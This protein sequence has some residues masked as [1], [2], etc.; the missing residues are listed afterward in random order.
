LGKDNRR[1]RFLKMMKK[2]IESLSLLL[3]FCLSGFMVGALTGIVDAW[4]AHRLFH[5]AISFT[6]ISTA[7]MTYSCLWT[8]IGLFVSAGFGLWGVLS[9]RPVRALRRRNPP[10]LFFF[11]LSIFLIGFTV[12]NKIYLPLA[13]S[14]KSL[15]FDLGWF[16]FWVLVYRYTPRISA[17][18]SAR[19]KTEKDKPV[20]AGLWKLGRLGLICL[21]ILFVIFIGR[22]KSLSPLSIQNAPNIVLLL[23]DDLRADHLHCYGYDKPISPNIDALSKEG[24]LFSNAYVAAPWTLPS[25]VSLFTS[26][27]PTEHGINDH[28]FKLSSKVPTLPGELKKLGYRVGIFTNSPWVSIRYGIGREADFFD[29]PYLSIHHVFYFLNKYSPFKLD[30][31]ITRRFLF[32]DKG[33]TTRFLNWSGSVIENKGKFFAYLHLLGP[34][35]PF[36]S[37]AAYRKK[38]GLEKAPRLNPPGSGSLISFKEQPSLED[39]DLRELIGNY[40]AAIMY[41]E[42]VVG[43]LIEGLKTMGIYDDTVLII[44][45]D[46]GEEFYDHQGWY[47]GGSLYEEQSRI[48][49]ILAW[50]G[51]F[52]RSIRIDEQISQIDIMPM[53]LHLLEEETPRQTTIQ[54]LLSAAKEKRRYERDIIYNEVIFEDRGARAVREGRYKLIYGYNNKGKEAILLFDLEADP[55]EL[56]NIYQEEPEIASRLLAKLKQ[57]HTQ[58]LEKQEKIEKAESDHLTTQKLRAL[59]YL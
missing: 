13:H 53:L 18:V 49:L 29:R 19:R 59:G 23:I 50:P 31:G 28:R 45:S 27:Y 21:I 25:V 3:E 6:A 33:L 39:E 58:L 32:S 17:A 56:R 48:P 36:S 7:V 41:S 14:A 35:V 55:K 9:D 40:D 1:R 44:T 54:D 20:M 30:N 15:I 42:E 51:H 47:H 24:V 5:E 43:I 37:P 12:I 8:L 26:L 11:C 57:V 2:L 46:H 52:P 4:L 34:H 16:L 38:L 22:K 10:L